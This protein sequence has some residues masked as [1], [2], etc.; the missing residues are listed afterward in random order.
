MNDNY[1]YEQVTSMMKTDNMMTFIIE[2]SGNLRSVPNIQLGTGVRNY[3]FLPNEEIEDVLIQRFSD[4]HVVTGSTLVINKAALDD[5][6]I[7]S[8]IRAKIESTSGTIMIRI[9]DEGYT[10]TQEDYDKLS[11]VSLIAVDNCVEEL[12]D[13]NKIKL[14]NGVYKLDYQNAQPVV[15]RREKFTDM[16]RRKTFH[17]NHPLTDSEF[18][19]LR[20][21]M[22]DPHS[23]FNGLNPRVSIELDYFEPKYYEIFLRKLQEHHIPE[24]INIQF[25][26]YLLK[27]NLEDYEHLTSYPYEIDVAYSTCH[28]MVDKY[29]KEPYTANRIYYSQIEGGGKTSLENYCNVI[30]EVT[31]FERTVREGDYSPLEVAVLAKMQIDS[32]FIYD[33]DYREEDVDQWNNIN[34]SQ[35][36]SHNDGEKRRAVCMGFSSLYSLYLRRSGIPMF[37]YS[38][39]GHSRNIGRIQDPRYGVDSVSV[40][41]IT[42]DLP[43][44][45]DDLT[46][47]TH[48]MVAPRE[49]S[50]VTDRNFHYEEMNI[51]TTLSIPYEDYQLYIEDSNLA[52]EQFYHPTYQPLG[53]TCRMMELM[54]FIPEDQE[55]IDI[56]DHIY[57]ANEEGLMEGIPEEA[58][59]SAI[60]NVMRKQGKT[61]EEIEEY[62]MQTQDSYMDRPLAFINLPA[63]GSNHDNENYFV[64][65]ITRENAHQRREDL[66]N[67]DVDRPIYR[68]STYQ[69]P[70]Q[71]EDMRRMEDQPQITDEP[72]HANVDEDNPTRPEPTLIPI[73]DT[74]PRRPSRDDIIDDPVTQ[75]LGE[76][77]E[78]FIPGTNIHRPRVR[79]DYESDE[80]YVEFL[81]RFY[82]KYFPNVNYVQQVIEYCQNNHMNIYDYYQII[83]SLHRENNEA[84]LPEF[85]RENPLLAEE[86]IALLK[87]SNDE[88]VDQ[89][90]ANAMM[91]AL[92]LNLSDV[93]RDELE[94]MF[95]DGSERYNEEIHERYHY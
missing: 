67:S 68:N 66:M 59:E 50:R 30:R 33:P 75:E 14:Q 73:D 61:E 78:D 58:V 16:E 37:R 26:G 21:A 49:F 35:I 27:D 44:E 9:S 84:V 56:Y 2:T 6:K 54:G 20:M 88:M 32:Q 13:N 24:G 95:V 18:E 11:F 85:E 5:E 74:P 90:F 51:A 57:R 93:Q 28:D 60:R 91:Q 83:G 94:E 79:G 77:S 64:Q 3:N 55:T 89:Y 40:T 46:T 87:A 7:L 53:Y 82:E 1:V 52:Y 39:T 43:S 72:F 17:I 15:E 48:F 76:F 45:N 8:A 38:T 71:D 12:R 65:E 23:D 36:L 19:E 92:G 4:P 80:D 86:D 34:L 42:W 62:I 47:Y 81:R 10:L 41:D 63:D 22:E 31:E 70:P 29:Q 69:E 25:I